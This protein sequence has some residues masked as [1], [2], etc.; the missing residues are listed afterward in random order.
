MTHSRSSNATSSNPSREEKNVTS[1]YCCQ[2]MP[3]FDDHKRRLLSTNQSLSSKTTARTG[4]S[5]FDFE[6]PA[7]GTVSVHVTAS[8]DDQTSPASLP[9]VPAPPNNHTL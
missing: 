4:T 6:K 1:G 7:S 3:S 9:A 5:G 2:V 8:V